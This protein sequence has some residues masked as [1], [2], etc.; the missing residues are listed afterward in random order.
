[1]TLAIN[2]GGVVNVLGNDTLGGQPAVIGTNISTP[3]LTDL[4]GLIG[5]TVNASGQLVVP[6]N[7]PAGTYSLSYRICALNASAACDIASVVVTI[8]PA[9]AG[10]LT[11]VVFDDLND[12]GVQ[13]SDEPGLA[14]VSVTLNSGQT[15]TTDSQGRYAFNGLPPGSVMVQITLPNGYTGATERNAAVTTGQTAIVNFPLQTGAPPAALTVSKTA[16]KGHTSGAGCPGVKELAI[17]DLNKTPKPITW[18]FG[19]TNQGPTY[20]ANPVFDDAQLGITPGINQSR[21][22]LRADAVL[23][24]APG[25][26]AW[27]FVEEMRDSS[28]I[29]EVA[30]TLTPVSETGQPL[31]L[32]PAQSSDEGAILAYISDPPFGVKTG[33]VIEGSNVV[34]WNMVWINDSPITAQGVVI[35]DPL[36]AGMTF[37]GNLDCTPRG[38]TIVHRCAFDPPNAASPQ[39]QV[40]VIA[41]LAPDPGA[42]GEADATNA[43]LIHFDVTVQ[44]S[45]TTRTYQNQGA[46]EWDPDGDGA[47]GETLTGT[48]HDPSTSDPSDPIN[49]PTIIIIPPTAPPAPRRVDAILFPYFVVSDTVTSI[50]SVINQAEYDPDST[51]TQTLRYTAYYKH[52]ANAGDATA[53][54]EEANVRRVTS[55]NDLV[56]FDLGGHFGDPQSVLHEPAER[57]INA[58]YDAAHQSFA[59]MAGLQPVR[60]FLIVDNNDPPSQPFE[61]SLAG[62]MMILDFAQGAAWGYQA[63]NAAP[64]TEQDAANPVVD[65][66]YA[67][68]DATERAGEVLAGRRDLTLTALNGGISPAIPV[69]IM[70]MAGIAQD[71]VTTRFFVTPIG[72]SVTF[73]ANAVANPTVINER[74]VIGPRHQHRGDLTA[75]VLLTVGNPN[76]AANSDVFFDRDENPISGRIAQSVTCVGAIDVNTLM[77]EAV[78]RQIGEFGGW[79]A[80]A[81]R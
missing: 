30:V 4:G 5:A 60:G 35:T 37:L 25:A 46:I 45:Q 72:H 47:G 80:I 28:L 20:L 65:T 49:K 6:A 51:Q 76:D 18:C 43:L 24:L 41:D 27:W 58:R 66:L 16:Y 71:G 67:F 77:S 1:M 55:P 75:E 9:S 44:P 54:C 57:Q 79:S 10:A 74:A 39:S 78:L 70:P 69:A 23:P 17:V 36:P 11:G 19:V 61:N 62:E 34:R 8:T 68:E 56:T 13:N 81:V 32:P 31:G 29:N 73:P 12:N 33:E 26:T 52:G 21:A 22:Q 15:T 3:T 42:T 64:L 40:Q 53:A 38:S 2:N 50:V 63:Y 48:T 7:T 14:G 59:L